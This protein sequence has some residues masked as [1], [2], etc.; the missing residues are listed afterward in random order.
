M[1]PGERPGKANIDRL[2]KG[3]RAHSPTVNLS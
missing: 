3:D 2:D 1:C